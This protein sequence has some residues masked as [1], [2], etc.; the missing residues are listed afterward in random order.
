MPPPAFS[1][2]GRPRQGGPRAAARRSGAGTTGRSDPGGR[3]ASARAAR[4]RVPP[5]S[6]RLLPP[7][8]ALLPP[9]AGPGPARRRPGPAGGAAG[10]YAAVV[11]V[12]AAV[13]M[14]HSSFPRR[15]IPLP[16]PCLGG[17]GGRGAPP[18]CSMPHPAAVACGPPPSLC[19]LPPMATAEQR[20]RICGGSAA[21]WPRICGGS[22]MARRR[23]G[24]G[25][26]EAHPWMNPS[27][28][29]LAAVG[30]RPPALSSSPGV[31][32]QPPAAGVARAGRLPRSG[33]LRLDV[34]PGN[35]LSSPLPAGISACGGVP[36]ELLRRPQPPQSCRDD[37]PGGDLASPSTG[38]RAWCGIGTSAGLGA[39]VACRPDAGGRAE[40]GENGGGAAGGTGTRSPVRY[41][42]TG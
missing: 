30:R 18:P 12:C 22:V 42:E 39:S 26:A 23:L 8:R 6:S 11:G 9:R 37:G 40:R 27:S 24:G 41:S 16:P 14:E 25:S 34:L 5:S 3:A 17:R 36:G 19:L 7:R 32:H 28:S 29:L 35:R 10:P 4:L 13:A 15:Q 38:A 1:I 21:A 31:R 33:L 20:P 2:D